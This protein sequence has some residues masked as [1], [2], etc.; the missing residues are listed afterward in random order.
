V[1]DQVGLPV[2]RIT[3]L[4]EDGVPDFQ[5]EGCLGVRI[6]HVLDGHLPELA[7]LALEPDEVARVAAHDHDLVVPD[8]AADLAVLEHVG[9]HAGSLLE[10]EELLVPAEGLVLRLGKDDVCRAHVVVGLEEHRTCVERTVGLTGVVEGRAREDSFPRP[11]TVDGVEREILDLVPPSDG[12]LPDGVDGGRLGG[13]GRL[14]TIRPVHDRLAGPRVDEHRPDGAVVLLGARDVSDVHEVRVVSVHHHVESP[15][16]GHEL[17]EARCL[18]VVVE[19]VA[20]VADPVEDELLGVDPIDPVGDLLVALVRIRG[21]RIVECVGRDLAGLG[22]HDEQRLGEVRC[23]HVGEAVIIDVGGRVVGPPIVVE[24]E[25]RVIEPMRPV[26]AVPLAAQEAQDVVLIEVFLGV[27]AHHDLV[28]VPFGVR[29]A[30]PGGL[31][32][33]LSIDHRDRGDLA[34]GLDEARPVLLT[35]RVVERRHVVVVTINHHVRDD[36]LVTDILS[37]HGH[38]EDGR[39]PVLGARLT[40]QRLADLRQREQGTHVGDLGLRGRDRGVRRGVRDLEVVPPLLQ[41][42]VRGF[43]EGHLVLAVA[44]RQDRQDDE[45]RKE[46]VSHREISVVMRMLWRIARTLPSEVK[47]KA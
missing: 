26:G 11:H 21:V 25:R 10:V 3:V 23:P 44:A 24:L 4:D 31:G 29:C 45:Q 40:L 17:V 41:V 34:V 39:E 20:P 37:R 2:A 47:A 22:I 19:V 36:R 18:A 42:G 1:A 35:L 6:A 33:V 16:V 8:D 32:L 46:E 7:L 15:A 13:H 38:L 30:D 12:G 14:G 28:G 43:V 27:E 9:A 5:F